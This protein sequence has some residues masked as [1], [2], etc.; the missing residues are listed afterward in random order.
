MRLRNGGLMRLPSNAQAFQVL[1]LQAADEGRGSLLFGDSMDRARTALQP[2]MIGKSISSVYFEFPLLGDPFL[3]VTVLYGELDPAPHVASPAAEGADA[4][5]A[6]YAKARAD[7]PDISCGFEF[8]TKDPHFSAVG[9]HFQPRRHLDLVEPFCATIGEE[10][11]GLRYLE[12]AKRMPEGW[13]LSFFGLFRGRPHAPLRVCGYMSRE[14]RRICAH[15]RKSLV[16][17]FDEIGFVAYDD[18]MLEDI[19]E[20]LR[21]VS[22]DV[23]FQF[24]VFSDG[25]IGSTFAID[26]QFGIERPEVLQTVFE[27]GSGARVMG[28]LESWRI[29]DDRWRQGIAAAF[30]R[31]LPVQTDDGALEA[32]A[33]T[34]MP[35]WVKVRWVDGRLQPAKL[36]LLGTA[37]IIERK[38]DA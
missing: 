36:Y 35:Q 1:L 32:F 17:A 30:A 27:S 24:D 4:M 2:F 38:G 11:R 9:I 14:W 19:G 13:P 26:V 5:L 16:R 28:L 31:A 29:A 8:D 34:L 33:F 37:G 20:L 10:Q 15:D 3:D 7:F 6:W 18:A 22:H 23:D 12:L 21:A 25:T